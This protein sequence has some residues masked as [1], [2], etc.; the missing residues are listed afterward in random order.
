MGGVAVGL[1]GARDE[2]REDQVMFRT[3]LR[4]A[5]AVAVCLGAAPAR[6][7][8]A[9]LPRLIRL[10]VPAPP[11]SLTD[12]VARAVATQL[13]ARTGSQAIVENRGGAATLLGS[14][15]V[16]RGPKDG[17]ILLINSTSLLSAA[18]TMRQ[19]PLNVLT[20]L[21][22]V[23]MLMQSPLI[24][25]VSARSNIRTPAEL[26]AAARATRDGLTHGTAGVGS[27]A[28][29]AQE[30]LSKAAGIPIRHVPYTGGAPAVIDMMAG[31]ID[32]VMAVNTS[33]VP[34]TSSGQARALAVTSLEPSP[35][36]PGLPTMAS[37]AP[38]FSMELWLGV[39]APAGTPA[40]M[41]QRLNR[42]F[43]EIAVSDRLREI[44]STDGGV[45]VVQTPEQIRVFM[46]QSFD[47]FRRLAVENDIALE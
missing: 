35:A 44:A 25:A 38:G 4:L 26:V 27:T 43:N 11:G 21:T 19:P 29:I 47:S 6:A 41:V 7:Q 31:T 37:V 22:P 46:Q 42:E 28:H 10:V 1:A 5:M 3:I 18:A 12:V 2:Q 45:P 9:P 8:D 15:V 39:F 24:V 16:A 30:L 14:A 20:D 23:S 17:S 34:G 36:F 33:V 13:T 32:M 40:P